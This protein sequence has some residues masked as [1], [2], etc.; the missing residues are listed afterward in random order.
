M[1]IEETVVGG[2]AEDRAGLCVCSHQVNG[3]SLTDLQYA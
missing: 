1:Q 2:R 3:R